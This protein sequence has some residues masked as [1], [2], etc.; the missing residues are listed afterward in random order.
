V[1]WFFMVLIDWST[2]ALSGLEP[3]YRVLN[4]AFQSIR[5]VLSSE[6][7]WLTSCRSTWA[8]GFH[9]LDLEKFAPGMQVLILGLM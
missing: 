4:C 3:R 6:K 7:Y 5:C 2:P 1:Q 8:A 9:S